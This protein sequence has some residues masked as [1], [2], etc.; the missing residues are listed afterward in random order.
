MKVRIEPGEADFAAL[1]AVEWKLGECGYSCGA[2][3]R[4]A[5]IGV[6]HGDYAIAKWHNMTAAEQDALHGR[7]E[8]LEPATRSFRSGPLL[9][10]IADEHVTPALREALLRLGKE[11][12]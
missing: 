11:E 1:Y 8:A 9:V 2:M 7:I 5:P 12:A 3:Q 10:T 6:K 4:G